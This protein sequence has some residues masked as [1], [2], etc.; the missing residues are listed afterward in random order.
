[1]VSLAFNIYLI[2][3]L[4]WRIAL[5]THSEGSQTSLVVSVRLLV[6][7]AWSICFILA[8]WWVWLDFKKSKGINLPQLAL[9]CYLARSTPSMGTEGSR[10]YSYICARLRCK[11]STQIGP[12][13]CSRV[14]ARP[15][16]AAKSGCHARARFCTGAS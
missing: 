5:I 6:F 10:V 7:F 3:S 11:C 16:S 15:K 2:K 4:E 1:M 14:P 12:C 13:R 8:T 9:I